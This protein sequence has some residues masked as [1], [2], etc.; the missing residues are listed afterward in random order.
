MM[1]LVERIA[2]QQCAIAETDW[3]AWCVRLEQTLAR[4]P[5][6]NPALTYFQALEIDPLSPL[7]HAAFRPDFAMH[8]QPAAHYD[9][10]LE[11]IGKAWDISKLA[12]L[13]EI[14]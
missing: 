1:E 11:R 7:R 10:L 2:S 14:A 3:G 9:A 8:G 5:G 6:D 13:G 12:K 4:V